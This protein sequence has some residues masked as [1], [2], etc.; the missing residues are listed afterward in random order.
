MRYHS[1]SSSSTSAA[2]ITVG[3]RPDGAGAAR[4]F[5]LLGLVVFLMRQDTPIG[6]G[7]GRERSGL[8]ASSF[9]RTE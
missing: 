9:G 7:V 4:L 3:E 5:A 8:S 6:G 2:R 1:S